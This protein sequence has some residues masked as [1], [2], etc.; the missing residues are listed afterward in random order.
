MKP[1]SRRVSF[2][3]KYGYSDFVSCEQEIRFFVFRDC[4]RNHVI[5]EG[6]VIAGISCQPVA[7]ILFVEGRLAAAGRISLNR[8]ETA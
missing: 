1:G 4:A 3:R 7:H 6:A 8:P 5:R 2:F